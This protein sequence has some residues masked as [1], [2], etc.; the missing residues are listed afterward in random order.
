MR[1]NINKSSSVMDLSRT[2]KI[3]FLVIWAFSFLL[4]LTGTIII[5]IL[6]Y[7]RYKNKLSPTEVFA[8]QIWYLPILYLLEVGFRFSLCSFNYSEASNK[9]KV[10]AKADKLF[11]NNNC[12]RS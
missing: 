6:L 2:N 1:V 7:H 4:S 10:L 5:L 8:Y 11:L 12:D 3:I 9:D